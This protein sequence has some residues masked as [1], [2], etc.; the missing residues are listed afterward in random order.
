ML[1]LWCLLQTELIQCL[2]FIINIDGI[3][4]TKLL[5]REDLYLLIKQTSHLHRVRLHR[6]D[7]LNDVRRVFFWMPHLWRR[8]PFRCPC[9]KFASSQHPQFLQ[10]AEIEF[11]SLLLFEKAFAASVLVL[12]FWNVLAFVVYHFCQQRS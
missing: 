3:S 2:Q 4:T 1:D 9:W 10:P 11:V 12:A 5:D 8:E 6:W 7:K